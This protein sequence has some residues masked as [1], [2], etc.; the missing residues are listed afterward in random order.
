VSATEVVGSVSRAVL[1]AALA[2]G[3]AKPDGPVGPLLGPAL[4]TVGVGQ[5]AA[6]ARAALAGGRPAVVVLVDGRAAGVLPR[7]A[8]GA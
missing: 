4:P 6:E 5:P 8:L 1:A 3:G 7:A 2:N